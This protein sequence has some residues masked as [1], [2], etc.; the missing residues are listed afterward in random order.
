MKKRRGGFSVLSQK[1]MEPRISVSSNA[2][3]GPRY[4]A[5]LSSKTFHINN[6]AHR[7]NTTA[8]R[9]RK[10]LQ[11]IVLYKSYYYYY[12]YYYYIKT[13]G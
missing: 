8:L 9:A 1:T 5:L 13:L 4:A 3:R 11:G 7:R 12:Y 2:K 10:Y 6:Y